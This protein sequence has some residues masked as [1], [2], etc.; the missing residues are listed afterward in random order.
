MD[1]SILK[2][3]KNQFV[4]FL[5]D[6]TKLPKAEKNIRV[7][8]ASNIEGPFTKPSEPITGDYWAEGPTCLKSD[9]NYIVYFDKYTE[10]NMGA[11]TSS[12]SKN[13]IDISDKISF[14]GDVRHETVF[15]I[16]G[17]PAKKLIE[18]HK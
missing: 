7:V 9:K 10:G 3:K 5:K 4:M 12:D 1:G 2:L 8:T 17:K 13:G 14:T 18:K 6:E 15:R 16:P 11:V